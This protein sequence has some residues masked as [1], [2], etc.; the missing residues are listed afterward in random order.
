MYNEMGQKVIN[1]FFFF[2]VKT[3]IIFFKI[4]KRNLFH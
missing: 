1:Q 2:F 4:G 3:W